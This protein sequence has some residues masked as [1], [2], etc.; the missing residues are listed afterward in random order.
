MARFMNLWVGFGC[1]SVSNGLDGV[2]YR[3]YIYILLNADCK[4]NG[5]MIILKYRADVPYHS[6]NGELNHFNL[7]Y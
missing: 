3:A 5:H 6:D 1:V 7:L 2:V 4:H